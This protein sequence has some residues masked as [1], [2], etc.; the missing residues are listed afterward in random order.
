MSG[1][2]ERL[3]AARDWH[4]GVGYSPVSLCQEAAAEIERLTAAHATARNDALEEAA[5]WHEDEIKSI[6]EQVEENN[7]Y[8]LRS[9]QD[10]A[11]CEANE[12]CHDRIIGHSFAIKAIRAL[13]GGDA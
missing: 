4:S 3:R 5:K 10:G 2:V 13:K 8:R 9:G 7:A 11:A 1:L 12:A 6:K